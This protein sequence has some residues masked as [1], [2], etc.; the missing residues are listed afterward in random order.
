M[1]FKIE[2]NQ[3]LRA[4]T[5][6]TR[7][8]PK[9]SEHPI[10]L[11]VLLIAMDGS[12]KIKASDLDRELVE[13]I[14]ANIKKPGA[15]AVSGSVLRDIA[16][17]LPDG[18]EVTV[19]HDVKNN[20]L[21]IECGRI[22]YVLPT[23]LAS[24]FPD[25]NIGK[26][27]H[28]FSI[29]SSDLRRMIEKSRFAI[30]TEETRYYL[31]GIYMHATKHNNNDVLRAVATDGHRLAL[32]DT[33]IPHGA[34][35]MPGIIIPR[36]T[37]NE[38]HRMLKDGDDSVCVSVS[39]S[40]IHFEMGSIAFASK[41]IDATFPEYQRIVPKDKNHALVVANAEFMASVN[42]V[43]TIS[44]VDGK[45]IK[46][47]IENGRIYLNCSTIDGH[48]AAD[49]IEADWKSNPID[50]SF[51][52]KYLVDICGQIDGQHMIMQIKD[53]VSPVVIKDIADEKSMYILMPMR[54]SDKS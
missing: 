19:S 45:S 27:T 22:G 29:A 30:S 33:D 15:V 18:S 49:E 23:M 2:R 14:D 5:S 53:S 42:R 28:Q 6:A 31:N 38:L 39:Q 35:E 41:L 52:A 8:V 25:L 4:L 43:S 34:S 24:D 21:R 1:Q 48:S 17:K 26:I 50:I 36:K 51:S 7:I 32:S 46:L 16:R 54:Y 13:V 11:N 10:L 44:K 37:I 40:V 9:R 47:S 3:L 12:L 20:A